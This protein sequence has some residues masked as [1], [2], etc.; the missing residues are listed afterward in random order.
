VKHL[1]IGFGEDFSAADAWHG[2]IRKWQK[3]L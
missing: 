1:H 2:G 3:T